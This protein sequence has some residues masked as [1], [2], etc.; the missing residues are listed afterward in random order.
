MRRNLSIVAVFA[1]LALGAPDLGVPDGVGTPAEAKPARKAKERA[2][3]TSRYVR[4]SR[5]KQRAEG[6]KAEGGEAS[7]AVFI[8]PPAA[9]PVPTAI[10]AWREEIGAR[11][12][13]PLDWPKLPGPPPTAEPPTEPPVQRGS[14]VIAAAAGLL[15]ILACFA[16]VWPCLP[17]PRFPPLRPRAARR[18]IWMTLRGRTRRIA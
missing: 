14:L 3:A 6:R 11:A 9:L 15:F 2:A 16:I 1:L 5:A 12:W 13:R 10:A 17:E 4:A 18:S 7:P 8:P